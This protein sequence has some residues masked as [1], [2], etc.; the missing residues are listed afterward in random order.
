MACTWWY[1]VSSA[2]L[3]LLIFL[4]TILF[5]A[6]ASSSPAFHMM[7]SAYKLN[8][9]GDNTQPWCTP[10]P[11]WNNSI[12]PC[13]VLMVASWPAHRFFR[14]QVKWSHTPISLRIFQFVIHRVK[15]FSIV[16]LYWLWNSLAFSTIQQVLAIWFLVLYLFKT[17]LY[18]WNLSVH[19]LQE[20]SLKDFEHNI[21]SI[22]NEGNCMVVWVFFGIVLLWDW[23]ETHLFQSCGHCWVFQIWLH[24]ECTTVTA[25]SFRVLNISAGIPSCPLALF[26][27]VLPNAHLTSQSRMSG[28][29]WVTT[30][31]WLSRSLRPFLYSSSVYYCQFFLISSASLMSL[32]SSSLP[33]CFCRLSC[34]SLHEM[35]LWCL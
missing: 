27:V 29:R 7:F 18:I 5:P 23:N 11:I 20:P 14:W 19:R 1:T 30:P 26:R 15:G 9:Q 8:E 24:I 21:A 16:N 13:L 28:S 22:W 32:I 31:S 35:F 10:F 4:L 12:V 33:Y 2:Y 6:C 25:S 3:R 34:P 17:S